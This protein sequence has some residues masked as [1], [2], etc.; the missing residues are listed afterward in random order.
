[1]ITICVPL[2]NS[3]NKMSQAVDLTG[4][5]F[6]RLTILSRAE[7][8]RYGNACW[9]C[10]C[11]C[12]Q[13]IV[14]RGAHLRSG[15]TRS[16]GCL[17]KEA[18]NKRNYRHGLWA[19]RIY[20]IYYH[21][22]DRC[23]NRKSVSYPYYGGRGIAISPEWDTFE[24]FYVWA[25][26]NGYNYGMTIDRINVFGNYEPGNCRWI[27]LEAQAENTTRSHTITIGSISKTINEWAE[28]TGLSRSTILS[29]LQRGW[30]PEDAVMKSKGRYNGNNIF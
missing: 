24:K 28:E 18:D 13:T 15:N 19:S 21:M 25:I 2:A 7:N 8:D 30:S 20:R 5:K 9:L 11:D 3:Q 16:C 26:E 14:A 6:G 22:R 27:P 12:G 1:M 4:Q 23:Y 10:A 29:R 17:D